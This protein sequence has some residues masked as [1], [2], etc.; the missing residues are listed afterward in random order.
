MNN[1]TGN[2]II[3]IHAK[4]ML[5]V[6]EK[7]ILNNNF[8]VIKNDQIIDIRQSLPTNYKQ[9]HQIEIPENMTLLP[10][11]INAHDHLQFLPIEDKKGS[12][13]TAND[14]EIFDRMKMNAEKAVKFGVT[15][16]RDCGSRNHMDIKL[17][18]L[19]RKGSIVGPNLIA[20]GKPLTSTGG[21]LSW[22]GREVNGIDEIANAVKE[23]IE[24]GADFIKL[25][26]SGGMASPGT[27]IASVQ[28]SPE[29]LRAAV[30]TTHSLGKIITAHAHSTGA[31][32]AVVKAGFDMIEHCSWVG[33]RGTDYD[34]AIVDLIAKKGIFVVFTLATGYPRGKVKK[35]W[36]RQVGTL[37]N[38]LQI[39][40]KMIEA[41]VL[42]IVGT[43]DSEFDTLAYE[44]ELLAKAGLNNF[45]VIQAATKL[46][47]EALGIGDQTGCI[48]VGK[49]ADII[50]AI[51]NPL[52]NIHTLNNVGFV[53]KNGQVV[54]C[55]E[56]IK[57][58]LC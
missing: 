29:E 48:K 50:A 42:T 38:R 18:K 52:E 35:E 32:K 58:T 6:I 57:K 53:M 24:A 11:L 31:I 19:L 10:G 49:R 44:I 23:E 37:E 20:S 45:E 41:G 16:L 7:K 5:D 15:T 22:M 4:K 36:Q 33:P 27:D 56:V 8:I 3:V 43:D 2:N 51:G 55:Q 47:A 13:L 54:K 9:L 46:S 34:R 14:S 39:I 28:F 30:E 21:H 26:A 17:A 40:Q 1:K 25:I 12:F